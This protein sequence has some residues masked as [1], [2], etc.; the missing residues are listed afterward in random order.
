MF[1][2]VLIVGQS[3]RQTKPKKGQFM[4]F[5]RGQTGTKVRCES[6]LLSQ[7]KTPEFTKM[8]EIHELFLLALSLVWFARTTPE[9]MTL[10][11]SKKKLS[12]FF[13]RPNPRRIA[14]YISEKHRAREPL[15]FTH[16]LSHE[17]AHENAHGSVHEDDHKNAHES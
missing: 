6:H 4:N 9:K 17:S 15:N 1:S 13:L 5:S 16:D 10:T 3:P 14:P 12:R 8:G 11:D 7:G 2:L